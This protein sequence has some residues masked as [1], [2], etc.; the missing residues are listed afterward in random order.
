MPQPSPDNKRSTRFPGKDERR[1]LVIPKLNTPRNNGAD[2]KRKTQFPGA[3]NSQFN[4]PTAKSLEAPA[5]Q[6]E[7]TPV[8]HI[9]ILESGSDSDDTLF[10][11]STERAQPALVVA[12]RHKNPWL[13]YK[14][15]RNVAQGSQVKVACTRSEPVK[16]VIVKVA[17]V[18][19]QL[20]DI[21]R[22]PYQNLVDFRE[23]YK[24]KNKTIIILEFIQ[25][26]L[27]QAI[28][29]P[30]PFEEVHVSTV[31]SQSL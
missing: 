21:L 8:L 15:L 19:I 13:I 17:S 27:R 5:R 23:A 16:M 11:S 2:G 22:F 31:C 12:I 25:V 7:L 4:H 30:F 1:G 24:Y 14:P 20:E 28:A 6:K 29:I 10:V 18:A 9:P 3:S 26:S